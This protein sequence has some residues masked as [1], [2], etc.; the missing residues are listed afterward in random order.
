MIVL[1]GYFAAQIFE[2]VI[3]V[4][5][6]VVGVE[7]INRVAQKIPV[8]AQDMVVIF[9]VFLGG[10]FVGLADLGDDFEIWP[11]SNALIKG[12]VTSFPR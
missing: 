11:N 8:G 2:P 9:L 3:G 12:F 7:K 1:S 4:L 10:L 6:P 5:Q